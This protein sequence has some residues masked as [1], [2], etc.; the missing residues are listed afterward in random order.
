MCQYFLNISS[1][2]EQYRD[3]ID[4]RDHFDHYN[5][6]KKISYR[7]IPTP[8]TSLLYS[9]REDCNCNASSFGLLLVV[10]LTFLQ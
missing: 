8:H 9:A 1:T 10:L 3:N 6:Y 5:H 7:Y 4:N 2:F